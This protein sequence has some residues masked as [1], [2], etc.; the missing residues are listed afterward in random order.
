MKV[1]PGAIAL[2]MGRIDFQEFLKATLARRDPSR[3]R[4]AEPDKMDVL[5][6]VVRQG[7]AE[8][9]FRKS[10]SPGYWNFPNINQCRHFRRLECGDEVLQRRLLVTDGGQ[11]GHGMIHLQHRIWREFQDININRKKQPIS[12]LSHPSDLLYRLL[13][14]RAVL[15]DGDFEFVLGLQVH[16]EI[17]RGVE[18]LGQAERRIGGD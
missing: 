12:R 14:L 9:I 3:F 6:T 2:Q 17:W 1:R 10:L 13:D 15:Q 18:R 16:P 5:D 7:V 8:N 4:I 11:H